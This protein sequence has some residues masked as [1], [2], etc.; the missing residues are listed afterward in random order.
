MKLSILIPTTTKRCGRFFTSMVENIND[1][2]I[3]NDRN[4]I[5]VLG[6]L[7]NYKKTIGEK[8]NIL[9]NMASGQFV[10]F[11]DDDDRITDDFLFEVL[12]A[13]DNNNNADCI[14]YDMMC[15]INGTREILSKFGI[16][17]EYTKGI[18]FDIIKQS[19]ITPELWYGKPSHN[20]V[21]ASRIAKSCIFP[22][23]NTG[24]D[25]AWVKQAW[26]R[27]KKQVRI[28]KTLYYYDAVLGKQY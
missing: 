28:D 6:L 22:N 26:P 11:L 20:M 23:C 7:D 8:R 24:E 18:K 21:W 25:F 12:Y 10:V 27:I 1:Q 15:I 13:I 4:D 14:V 17:F 16:E 3:K 5:E 9:L 2:I 19:P